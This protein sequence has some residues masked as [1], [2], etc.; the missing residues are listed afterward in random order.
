MNDVNSTLHNVIS[1]GGSLVISGVCFYVFSSKPLTFQQNTALFC[2]NLHF[3][4]RVVE[5]ITVHKYTRKVPVPDALKE[6][7]YYWIF[8]FWVT[9]SYLQPRY[10]APEDFHVYCG[11]VVWAIAELCNCRCH[12]ILANLR[13]ANIGTSVTSQTRYPIPKGF[14]FEQLTCPHY[15]CE[16]F[17][18][19]GF[20]MMNQTLAA[21]SFMLVSS[22]IMISWATERRERYLQIHPRYPRARTNII[23]PYIY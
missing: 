18:W 13:S 15:F 1:Y 19:V 10:V 22:A 20:W 5:S 4:R 2:W 21:L 7:L 11:F 17:T 9:F 6:Y 12:F 3:L 23:F 14:L 16:I 8:A